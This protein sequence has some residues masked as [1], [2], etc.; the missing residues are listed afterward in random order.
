[1]SQLTKE[2][3]LKR[4]LLVLL[5]L[6]TGLSVLTSAAAFLAF[7]RL[8]IRDSLVR[9]VRTFADIAS[10]SV[11]ADIDFGQ[12][13]SASNT[14]SSLES[15]KHIRAACIW[16]HRG[17]FFT[18][19]PANY[20][21][22]HFPA[23]PAAQE[24]HAFK[25]DSMD[26]FRPIYKGD[27][28]VGTIFIR[29][30]LEEINAR[31]VT[32]AEVLGGI[33]ILVF[34]L[35]LLASVILQKQVTEPMLQLSAA[36][37]KISQE[38]DYSIRL[39]RLQGGEIGVLTDSLN[40]MFSQIE[41]RD[42][43]LL[44]YQEHLEE[45][46]AQRSEQ[47]L[48][49]NTQLLLAKEKAEEANQAKS[50]F[51]ANMSHELRTP[52]N[53]ILLYSELLADEVRERGMSE[54]VPDLG[55]IQSAGKHLLSLIDDIL[56]LSKI[57][58]GRMSVFIED[59][60]LPMLLKDIEATVQPLVAKNRNTFNLE[61]D[62]SIS[63]IRTD[64]RMLRQVLYNLLNNAAKFTEDGTIR[65]QVAPEGGDVLFR[66]LDSGIGMT[67]EQIQRVFREF[68]QADESTTRRFGGTGLGLAL[69]R[70]LTSILNGELSVE[71]EPGKGSTFILRIPRG[72]APSEAS[73]HS[74]LKPYADT[75]QRKVL[76]IDDDPAMREGLSRMLTQEGFWAAVAPDGAE[77]LQLARTLHP[78]MITLDIMM[79]GLD[80][81]Q[82]LAQLKEDP[83]LCHIP[84][85]LLTLLDDRARG[86]ALGA[87]E[88][89]CKPISRDRLVTVLHNLGLNPT[90]KPLL[91]V[92][93]N[94]L[95]LDALT[96]MLEAEGWEVRT[97]KDGFQAM[98]HL[99]LEHPSM[100]LLDLMLPGMDGFQ[101]V[102]EMQ[103]QEALRDIPVL[104][105]TAKNLTQ[106]DLDRLTGPLVK[107]VLRKGTCSKEDLLR[108]VRGLALRNMAR[109]EENG[110]KEP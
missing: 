90:D 21:A 49:A 47:L 106:E 83:E 18:G 72:G 96:R 86:F 19:Y 60:D 64:L 109:A 38:K 13:T 23:A 107:Q 25:A 58:A 22:T 39:E 17:K 77:G 45:Q 95:T 99:Q 30:D 93:D 44:D 91:L 40:D 42:A 78:D 110:R 29:T 101:L 67:E 57:E 76:I 87:S 8:Q 14:L 79:P 33:A 80:G 34:G 97:A 74:F 108:A 100:V 65:L 1:V 31:L 98:E 69:S 15:N 66:I 3:S 7:E 10:K 81:W 56:D 37:R 70:K 9:T 32:T 102:A 4:R 55:K 63:R 75:H 73:G 28:F 68:T 82:V 48:K 11:D 84:V 27:R 26:Y 62:P 46:V 92:E 54:L 89:L 24:S 50:T 41:S 71:S 20:P 105:L 59:C 61:L 104:V 36:A 6:V 88:Y 52:L 2:L 16:D 53:A 12:A 103:R 51:L 35:V 94:P 85:V 5:V 43:Q